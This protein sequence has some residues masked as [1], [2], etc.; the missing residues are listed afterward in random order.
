MLNENMKAVA[1]FTVSAPELDLDEVTRFIGW[2][3]YVFT[4][5]D[6]EDE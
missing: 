1:S 5:E 4:E 3:I 6:D 2:S